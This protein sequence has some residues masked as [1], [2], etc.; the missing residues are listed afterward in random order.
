MMSSAMA[1][2]VLEGHCFPNV[3]A[4]LSKQVDLEHDI[5]RKKERA[6]QQW[7]H[8]CSSCRAALDVNAEASIAVYKRR[9]IQY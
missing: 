3:A 8:R 4:D 2:A 7:R 6:S 9:S 5:E 1:C